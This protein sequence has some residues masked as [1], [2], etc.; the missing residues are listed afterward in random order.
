MGVDTPLPVSQQESGEPIVYQVAAVEDVA[1]FDAAKRFVFQGAL[2]SKGVL[3]LLD[4]GA[5]CNLLDASVLP[6][7]ATLV[8][9]PP[10]YLCL[11]N[12]DRLAISKS[13]STELVLGSSGPWSLSAAV[14][15]A[16]SLV[17]DVILG[18]PFM[19]EHQVVL[20]LFPSISA[21]IGKQGSPLFT[22]WPCS[23]PVCAPVTGSGPS[24]VPDRASVPSQVVQGGPQGPVSSSA[25]SDRSGVSAVTSSPSVVSPPDP[26]SSLI[27]PEAPEL[28][29]QRRLALQACSF[30]LF[31]KG[32]EEMRAS[33]PNNKVIP[34]LLQFRDLF[35]DALPKCLPPD[36]GERNHTIDLIPGVPLP[37]RQFY[38]VG[39]ALLP[40]LKAKLEDMVS[41]RIIELNSGFTRACSPA[42]LVTTG[43]P[44][45]V[46]DYKDINAATQD[47]TQVVPGIFDI[48]DKLAEAEI[49]TTSDMLSGYF[50]LIL[51]M[52]SRDLS[53]ITTPLGQYRY[54]VTA[55]GLKNAGTDF[56][57]AVEACLKATQLYWEATLN[58][59]D[60]LLVFSKSLDEHLEHLFKV[61]TAMRRDGWF[62][63]FAKSFFAALKI[64]ILGH[65]V[66]KGGIFPDPDYLSRVVDLPCPNDAK[67]KIKSLQCVL[68]VLGFY[69]RFIPNF[70][71]VARPL[72]ALLK[73]NSPWVWSD[74]H[75]EALARLS[76]SLQ[77][78]ADDG[79]R[80]FNRSRPTRIL[81][82]ASG[83]G[84]GA[85][86]EQADENECW[87][88]VAFFSRALTPPEAAL[89][90]FERELLAI[91]AACRKWLGYLQGLHFSILCD[92]AALKNIASMSF[93]ARKRRIV[94]ML[95]FLR[96]LSFTWV[97]IPGKDNGAADALSRVHPGVPDPDPNA[98]L[99]VLPPHPSDPWGSGVRLPIDDELDDVL[100]VLQNAGSAPGFITADFAMECC[101]ICPDFP[102]EVP[103]PFSALSSLCTC[104]ATSPVSLG[105]VSVEAELGLS[106]AD[107]QVGSD[108]YCL[109]QLRE[110]MDPFSGMTAA[111]DAGLGPE[112]S[113]LLAPLDVI[114]HAPPSS[115][116]QPPSAVWSYAADPK[117]KDLWS[118]TAN[119]QVE[120]YRRDGDLLVHRNLIV[121]PTAAVVPLLSELHVNFGHMATRTLEKVVRDFKFW[122]V[123]LHADVVAFVEKCPTC[124]L[125]S[126]YNGM[127]FG[128]L[129]TRPAWD[130]A[131]EI[132]VDISYCTPAGGW[133]AIL[134]II[135]RFSRLIRWVPARRNWTSAE[136]FDAVI[137]HWVSLFGLPA[138]IRSDNGPIFNCG[139]WIA[140]WS[141]V[142]TQTSFSAPYHPQS[143]GIIERSFRTLKGKLKTFL[144]DS[145]SITW[146]DAISFVQGACNALPRE[147]LGGACPSEVMFGYRPRWVCVPALKCCPPSA[148]WLWENHNKMVEIADTIVKCLDK[149]FKRMKEAS[150]PHRKPWSPVVGDLVLVSQK[151]F[152]LQQSGS[153]KVSMELEFCGP[154]KITEVRG[155]TTLIIDYLGEPK[156]VALA[157]AKPCLI[158]PNSPPLASS[159]TDLWRVMAAERYAGVQIPL[160]QG[161]WSA[162][163]AVD[164]D[165][166]AD[167]VPCPDTPV[168]VVPQV[169][170][171]APGGKA[172]RVVETEPVGSSEGKDLDVLA[173]VTAMHTNSAGRV[174]FSGRWAN[175]PTPVKLHWVD[176]AT[177]LPAS[178]EWDV[179]EAVLVFL[180]SKLKWAMEPIMVGVDDGSLPGFLEEALFDPDFAKQVAGALSWMKSCQ[181]KSAF[182]PKTIARW[183]SIV[184]EASEKWG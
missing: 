100:A 165:P 92:C 142:G 16:G 40:V 1:P 38:K 153:R 41:C 135:D 122:W 51:E 9:R 184:A 101:S 48:L 77:K 54:N 181:S 164:L 98:L 75:N 147:S 19:F 6:R 30:K 137:L 44:R 183:A 57:R 46:G 174:S 145:K 21:V 50:Q 154:F 97:H 171:P 87:K 53:T 149:D 35:P 161:W 114:P 89:V 113:D 56:Q 130:K 150:N 133:D 125:K 24:G 28:A 11:A 49:F 162:P 74:E 158:P 5:T 52:A 103:V 18:T 155:K 96:T 88:P 112:W 84:V 136:C 110:L 148:H 118:R 20:R 80:V 132:A 127:I 176:L 42:F 23:F 36:R 47:R 3:C 119:G 111:S 177:W 81:T 157:L 152:N 27:I 102:R 107:L 70:S 173:K 95:L 34:L 85:V 15:P 172:S 124:L 79:L 117:W 131:M 82:D 13:V 14:A 121:V 94:T 58:Y 163:A 179:S 160:A 78:Q 55:M 151:A 86:L 159:L 90:N 71:T 143:N 99:Q 169:A 129:G 4:T 93:A 168:L 156:T 182:S 141:S 63:S 7:E 128:P 115:P 69:R 170:P 105:E 59:L 60:D 108:D 166:A 167:L 139:P 68:G 126:T 17:Y 67:D 116:P 64:K 72:T 134:G 140:R 22:L 138:I 178:S 45:L 12:R 180:S 123:S 144:Q 43:K 146:V 29:E 83:C 61:F 2:G 73:K 76:N 106:A 109:A 62:L 8:E 26:W 32:I 25:P 65:W 31:D 66:E 10:I 39:E 175:N 104:I 33:N 91:Y 37:Q 120:H